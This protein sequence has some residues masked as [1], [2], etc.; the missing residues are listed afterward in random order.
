M[1]LAICQ[2]LASWLPEERVRISQLRLH[3]FDLIPVTPQPFTIHTLPLDDNLAIM[4]SSLS[5]GLALY[6]ALPC[7][8]AQLTANTTT[9]QYRSAQTS[10]ASA[11]KPT[12]KSSQRCAPYVSVIASARVSTFTS[13]SYQPRYNLPSKVI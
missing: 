4:S 3:F 9:E 11:W 1:A 8:V 7:L 6:V 5:V 13:R 12:P 2:S 10:S